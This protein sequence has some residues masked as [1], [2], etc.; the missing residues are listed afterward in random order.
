M[1][2]C[3]VRRLINQVCRWFMSISRVSARA[4]FALLSGRGFSLKKASS[5][6]FCQGCR[7]R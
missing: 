5:F 1:R 3:F 6:C 7:R 2:L 4:S